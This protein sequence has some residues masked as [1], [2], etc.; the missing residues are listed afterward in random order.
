M[1]TPLPWSFSS[2]EKFKNCPKQF[3]HLKVVRDTKEEYGEAALWGDRVH[4]AFEA[5]LTG[6]APLDPELEPY[7]AYLDKIAAGSGT[8]H[9]EKQL[10]VN[11]GLTPCAWEAPD[12]WLRGIVDVLHVD[13]TRARVLDH[14]TGKPKP[15][16]L[17]LK[18][19]AL[20][21]FLHYPEV[22][23]VK[24]GYFWLKTKETT[25]ESYSRIDMLDLW[26]EFLPD[27][28][29]YKQAFDTDTWTPRP[30]GLCRGWCPV[31]GC[32]FHRPFPKR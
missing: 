4:T 28:K 20:L 10:A 2:L 24:T 32:E 25:I 18:L 31:T 3:F 6:E 29:Q 12:V 8:M 14:K 26:N 5:Y 22:K 23:E 13:G 21:V 16:S 9:V 19:F 17:Q 1:A 7:R 27:L 15:Q 30:S 11:R